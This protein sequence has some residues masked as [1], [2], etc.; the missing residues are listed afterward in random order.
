MDIQSYK[1]HGSQNSSYEWDDHP[2]E[3][4]TTYVKV[5]YIGIGDYSTGSETHN[6]LNG[7]SECL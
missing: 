6:V 2:T 1:M 4:P 5:E 7:I 3:V